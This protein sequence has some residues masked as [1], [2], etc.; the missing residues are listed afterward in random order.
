MRWLLT[1]TSILFIS[2]LLV[3]GLV[4]CGGGETAVET[5]SAESSVEEEPAPEVGEVHTVK[6]V[7]DHTG[8]YFEP[9][10]ITIE[11]G[12]KIIWEMVSGAPHNVSFRNQEIPD[13]AKPVLQEAD[14]F[15]SANFSVPGQTYEIHFTEDYPAGEYNY[16]CEP[17]VSSDMRGK[18]VIE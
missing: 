5:T 15:V 11:P 18:V 9:E 1:R 6:M 10:K 17:H 2:G 13:G 7:G 4:G 3:I 16:L 8:F 12:D 14:K